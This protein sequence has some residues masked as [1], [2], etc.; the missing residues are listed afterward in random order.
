MK[1]S[2][3]IFKEK[4]FRIPT[5]QSR[6]TINM[7]VMESL[8]S[9]LSN[10]TDEFIERNQNIIRTNFDEHLIKESEYINAV[11][12]STGDKRRVLNRF[13]LTNEIL[14]ENTL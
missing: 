6:G 13:G 8:I 9:F 14:S 10:K 12:F 7:A 5:K 11:Q 3:N 2:Y 1:W 4:N